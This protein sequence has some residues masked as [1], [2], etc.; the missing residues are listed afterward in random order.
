MNETPDEEADRIAARRLIAGYSLPMLAY[1][2]S[3]RSSRCI[4]IVE[5]STGNVAVSVLVYD[6]YFRKLFHDSGNYV[7]GVI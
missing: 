1:R 5:K 3:S 6:A 4:C 7:K 2:V